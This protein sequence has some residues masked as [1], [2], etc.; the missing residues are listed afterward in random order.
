MSISVPSGQIYPQKN[1]PNRR[2]RASRP[3][4][5]SIGAIKALEPIM[6][7]MATSGSSRRKNSTGNL[8]A[9]G[10]TVKRNSMI[11]RANEMPWTPFL[12][13]ET[14]MVFLSFFTVFFTAEY[15]ESAE[16]KNYK[17]FTNLTMP[18]FNVLT[19]KLINKPALY[20]DSFK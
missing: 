10:Y 20:P 3:I 8:P 1:L 16:K 13:V 9:K 7:T 18:F 2:V 6:L 12:N 5:Q 17:L 4:P 19:L 15:A 14:F 11:K